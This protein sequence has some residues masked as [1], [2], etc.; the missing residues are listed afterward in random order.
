MN[1]ATREVQYPYAFDENDNLVFIEDVK[2]ET[3]YDHSYRCPNCG[4]PMLPRLGDHNAHCFAHSEN[5]ACGV[6]SYIHKM[7]KLILTKRFNDR[8]HPFNVHFRTNHICKE[9]EGCDHYSENECE[10]LVMDRFDLHDVYDLPAIEEVRLKY[11]SGSSFQPDIIIQS[12]KQKHAPIYIEIFHKH[13]ISSEKRLSGQHIIE[14]QVKDWGDL[15]GLASLEIDESDD[16]ITFYN[17]KDRR[18][19]REVIKKDA[20][21]IAQAIGIAD[22]DRML[23]FCFKS[24]KGKRELLNDIRLIIYPSGKTFSYGIFEDEMKKHKQSAIAEITY[25]CQRVPDTFDPLSVLVKKFPKTRRCT[26]CCHCLQNEFETNK[27]C[28]LVKNGSLRKNTFDNLKGIACSSFEMWTPVDSQSDSSMKEG[29]D[30]VI[31]INPIFS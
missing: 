22:I 1:K 6:E 27:W 13:R 4:H 29:I 14:I 28:D 5:Q 10:H 19:K 21:A 15:T 2:K 20:E 18:L 23:P 31:W 30:Y 25:N 11:S 9:M 16:R 17:F 12:S 7:A 3:R 24:K 8:S 26:M